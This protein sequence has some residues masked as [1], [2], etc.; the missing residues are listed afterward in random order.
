MRLYSPHLIPAHSESDVL[1]PLVVFQVQISVFQLY[2]DYH[3][4]LTVCTSPCP[5]YMYNTS[6][7]IK[8][9]NKIMITVQ[10]NIHISTS[11]CMPSML[12]HEWLT[13][14]TSSF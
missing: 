10:I 5:L 8:M 11:S 6:Y 7:D 2:Q 1:H 14:K 4:Q 12:L 13:V 9:P 3:L